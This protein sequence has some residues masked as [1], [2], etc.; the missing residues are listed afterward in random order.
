MLYNKHN[1]S[2][3]RISSKNEARPELAGVFFTKEK[4]V[5]T[6]SIRLLEVST[7]TDVKAQD[8]SQVGGVSAMLGVKPFIV[9]AKRLKEI[10]IPS[11]KSLPILQHIAIKHLHDDRVE[12]LTTNSESVDIKSIP[13]VDATFPD[14]EKIFPTEKP[15]IEID[16]NGEMFGELLEIMAKMNTQGK[17][18]IKIYGSDKPIVIEGGNTNQKARGMQMLLRS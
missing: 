15:K 3:I 2:V 18:T 5:A 6:D 10:K 11:N 12:F 14:Y 17:V 7:P 1:L 8:F 16:I 4:T 13:R 9:N